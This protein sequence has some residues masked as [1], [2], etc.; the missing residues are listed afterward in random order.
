MLRKKKVTNIS[1]VSITLTTMLLFILNPLTLAYGESNF[2]KLFGTTD[3]KELKNIIKDSEKIIEKNPNDKNALKTI[4]IAYHNLAN[5]KVKGASKKAVEYLK[6]AKKLYPEDYLI[7]ATLGSSWTL[8]GRDSTDI[9][10][11]MSYVNKGTNMIDKAVINDPDNTTIRM[12]RANNSLGIPKFF[13][14]RSIAKKD[15]L[16]LEEIIKR[17][18]KEINLDLQTQV[19]Y[20]LGK[21]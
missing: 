12:L 10:K 3:K 14:R 6:K 18:Q 11:K 8:V 20:K 4:G 5:E 21:V 7:L 19:Y 1:I 15:L 2:G 9:T 17:S 16:H 13:G